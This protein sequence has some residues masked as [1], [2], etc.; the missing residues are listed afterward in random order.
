M[1]QPTYE[2]L[3]AEFEAT[4]SWDDDK[5]RNYLRR[6]YEAG[7]IQRLER[8]IY[9]PVPSVP[10]VPFPNGARPIGTQD[11]Q[12]TQLLPEGVETS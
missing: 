11:T 6:A 8:G 4:H 1:S 7:R 5:A 10:S 2:D 12:G 9:T 3:I